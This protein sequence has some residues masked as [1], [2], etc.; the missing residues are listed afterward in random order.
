M[1]TKRIKI[2]DNN[3]NIGEQVE[4]ILAF[5]LEQSRK[6]AIQSKE[7]E[8]SQDVLGALLTRIDLL[9]KTVQFLT[10]SMV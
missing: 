8:L 9:G 4:Y 2:S 5:V 7:R 10:C 1:N 6:L 3:S